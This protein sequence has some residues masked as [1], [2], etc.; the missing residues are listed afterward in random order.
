MIDRQGKIAFVPPRYG[1][2]VVG[3]AEAVFSELAHQLADRG[4]AVEILTTCAR[5]HYTWANEY[6]S[7][8]S[9]DG[10]LTIRRFPTQTDTR[11]RHREHIGHRMLR[12]ERLNLAEQQLWINDS[13]RVSDLFHH[14]LD[15]G[16][17]YRALIFG[18]YM[19]WTT[20]AVGQVHPGK[21]FL[22][23]CLHREPAAE[24]DIYQP[25]F[26]GA[27]GIFFL[28][29]PEAA[30]ADDLF[31]LPARTAVVGA[32]VEIAEGH[33]PD[34]FRAR[35]GIDGPFIYYA[36]R[37]EWA[38][39]WTSL[40]DSFLRARLRTPELKLVTSGVGEV[41]VPGVT[42]P[43]DSVIDLGFVTESERNDAMAAAVAYVQPSA[44]ES[45][46]R[47]VMEAW[48]AGTAVIANGASEV[49]SWH[50]DR[51]GAGV[52]YQHDDELT[53]ALVLAAAA[54]ERFRHLGAA[55]RD[56]VIANYTPEDVV[57]RFESLLSEWARPLEAAGEDQCA[58]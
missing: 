57:D 32:G 39:G 23:P 49:V 51:S 20:F 12:G 9:Q 21:T 47:T 45:F 2:D 17:D 48:L 52:V 55:G 46:S 26:S 22:I 34:G 41:D 30:L 42:F 5:D 10:N 16:D 24:L 25:L 7:G 58:S 43:R 11:G 1:P 44:L 33:D 50:I 36:G 27:R 54:P 29:D 6:Q 37:R 35:H 28:S 8:V 13:L 18:P 3:G 15:H 56:Y 38:K 31:R 14:V 4:W 19:F 40:V 53:E